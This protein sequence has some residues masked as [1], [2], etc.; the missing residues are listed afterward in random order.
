MRRAIGTI[1]IFTF[2]EG[3]MS[4]V[5]HDLRVR[6]QGFEITLDGSAVKADFDLK[7]LAVEGPMHHGVLQAEQYDAGKKADVAKAM[8]G[9]VLH[10][11]K[12]PKAAYSGTAQPVADGYRVEGQLQLAGSTQALAFDVR[13]DGDTYRAEFELQ[14]SRW[15]VSQYK[16]M[17]GAIKLKDMFKVELALT[18]A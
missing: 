15:G 5:A 11:D 18:E 6:L 16:A 1:Q 17:L 13:K 10:T 3:I 14:P 12:H 9:E 8:H 4:A 2:K 7:S